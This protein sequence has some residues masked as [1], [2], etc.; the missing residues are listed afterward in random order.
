MGGRPYLW[1][2]YYLE[3]CPYTKPEPKPKLVVIVLHDQDWWGFLISSEIDEWIQFGPDKLA[4]QV[5]IKRSEHSCLVRDSWVDCLELYRFEVFLL[6]EVRD[7][8]SKAAKA[9]IL[10]AVAESKTIIR[11]QKRMI[12]EQG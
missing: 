12:K 3:K 8:V 4:T 11:R 10:A 7:P 5:E 2:I 6:K 9:A 1:R